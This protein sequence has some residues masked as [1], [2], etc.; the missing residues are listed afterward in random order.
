M[1]FDYGASFV[2]PPQRV[3]PIHQRQRINDKGGIATLWQVVILEAFI[4]HDLRQVASNTRYDD[5]KDFLGYVS[6]ILIL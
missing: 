2:C 5:P 3:V 6:T 1:Q 4:D